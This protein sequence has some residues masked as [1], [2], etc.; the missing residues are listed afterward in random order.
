MFTLVQLKQ[1]CSACPAQWEGQL[2]DGRKLYAR[3]RW[4][5][6][7]VGVADTLDEAVMCHGTPK[8]LLPQIDETGSLL[9]Q[10]RQMMA[11][12]HYLR[13]KEHH[14]QAEM[15]VDTDIGD[16]MDGFMDEDDFLG[17]LK[18]AG[19]RIAVPGLE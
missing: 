7:S 15:I 6:L 11:H 18:D 4:G 19:V 3:Y 12:S 16:S 13:Y 10:Y 14:G 2:E 8:R 17:Y 9:D 5:H 1:T